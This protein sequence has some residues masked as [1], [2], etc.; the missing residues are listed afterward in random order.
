MS[1]TL[2]T[3]PEAPVRETPLPFCKPVLTDA[4]CAAVQRVLAS[5][6]L[7]TGP[8]CAA[9]EA[10]LRTYWRVPHV[11]TMNSCTAALELGL[12]VLGVGPGT[13]VVTTP[14]T[15]CAT[16]NVIEHLG[17]V[18]WLV[19]VDPATGNLD[20]AL[21]PDPASL[22]AVRALLPVHFA[23]T[24]CDM[25]ALR[26]WAAAAD[27]PVLSDCAHA[28]ESRWEGVPLATLSDLAAFSFYATKNLT[29]GEGGALTCHNPD[30][31][32]RLRQLRLHGMSA[33]A[34]RRYE[35]GARPTYDVTEPGYKCNLTDP[36]AALGREQL[37]TLDARWARRGALVSR[38]LEGLADWIAKEYCRVLLPD[39]MSAETPA[40]AAFHLFPLILNPDRF[41]C[42]RDAAVSA[43]QQLGIG[44]SVHFTPVHQFSYYAARYSWT[45]EQF[46]VA[47]ALGAQEMSLPL[48]AG[49]ADEDVDDVLTALERLFSK[50]AR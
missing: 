17:A 49:L 38:Y 26:H 16:V 21:L 35:P 12:K 5:G 3:S 13:V 22:P 32:T 2:L 6:W 48:H 15:F 47:A 43:M 4:E 31:D 14:M 41:S 42:S 27:V 29:T 18:P 7:T 33:D 23:G 11:A 28:V 37:R 40:R 34:H 39:P 30:F 46:P 50:F 25:T 45:P 24:P 36:A 20:P 1:S 9:F 8:E 10:E 19:D 44:C